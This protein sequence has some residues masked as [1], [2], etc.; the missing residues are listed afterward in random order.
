[1]DAPP[2]G[3]EKKGRGHR[4]G[5]KRPFPARAGRAS[6]RGEKGNAASVV[7]GR[8]APEGTRDAEKIY[9]MVVLGGQ[10]RNS[11]RWGKV[12]RKKEGKRRWVGCWLHG[13]GGKIAKRGI[14][15][16]CVGDGFVELRRG[17]DRTYQP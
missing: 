2:I 11:D 5:V 6:D 14:F 1:M 13:S 4:P 17:A 7:G 16:T 10:T 15:I 12:T 8:A 9:G 3:K